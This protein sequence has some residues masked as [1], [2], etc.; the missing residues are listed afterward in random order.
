MGGTWE[1]M[2]GVARRILDAMLLEHG[3]ARLTHEVLVTFMAEVT[4]I[5]NARPLTSVSTDPDQ[6]VI[7][8]PAMLLTQKV[9]TPPAP[10][11]Q[12]D[13]SDLLRSQWRR[14]QSLATTFWDRWK[15]EYLS[16]LQDRRKWR[17]DSPN[18]REGD[19]VLLK[20][21]QMKRNDWPVGLVTNT[22]PS[23]DGEVRKVEV[24][25]VRKGEQRLFLRPVAEVILLVSKDTT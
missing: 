1:R 16:G 15:K 2:I 23:E 5:V 9:G 20:D 25:M 11:G 14:V 3:T 4:A 22:F 8:T 21:S 18:L 12:F 10:P 24:K 6:P 7:L 13:S 17:T 19:V